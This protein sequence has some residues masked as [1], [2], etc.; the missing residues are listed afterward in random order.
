MGVGG[1]P[2]G[3]Y[4]RGVQAAPS[5]FRQRDVQAGIMQWTL[6]LFR[7]LVPLSWVA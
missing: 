4:F 3:W 7:R 1:L 5:L 6:L 2:P